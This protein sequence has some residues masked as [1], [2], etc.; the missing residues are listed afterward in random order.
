M[1]KVTKTLATMMVAIML[2]AAALA[3]SAK[4][5]RGATP[6]I[7]VGQEPRPN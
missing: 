2:S 4:D 1:S 6:F 3:Q 5:V 7:P